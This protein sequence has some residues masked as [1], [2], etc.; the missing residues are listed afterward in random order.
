MQ[1][2]GSLLHF[3]LRA[4][5]EN[6]RVHE[7]CGAPLPLGNVVIGVIPQAEDIE[8][9]EERAGETLQDEGCG[10]GTVAIRAHGPPYGQSVFLLDPGLIVL[11]RA[12]AARHTD[13]LAPAPGKQDPVEA[14]AAVVG[15]LLPEGTRWALQEAME[16]RPHALPA[17]APYGLQLG[18]AHGHIH[19]DEGAEEETCAA[20]LT[21]EGQIA[22]QRPTGGGLPFPEGAERDLPCESHPSGRLPTPLAAEA[23]PSGQKQAASVAGLSPTSCARRFEGRRSPPWPSRAA[24]KI[25]SNRASSLEQA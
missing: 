16:A 18:P 14:L 24:T 5:H 13:P 23:A 25:D 6:L 4:P 15:M 20:F 2:S 21:V 11:A 17:E 12:G 10:P 19:T 8:L 1:D 7:A 9:Q 3:S 22:L